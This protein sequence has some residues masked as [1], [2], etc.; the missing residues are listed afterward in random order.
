MENIYEVV[1]FRNSC[2]GKLDTCKTDNIDTA[3]Y[4]FET[5]DSTLLV[6]P[7]HKKTISG[8]DTCPVSITRPNKYVDFYEVGRLG[9]LGGPSFIVPDQAISS[10][11]IGRLCEDAWDFWQIEDEDRVEKI[12]CGIIKQ[13]NA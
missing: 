3:L 4:W 8:H 7:G 13:N 2:T 11:F 9:E 6:Y 5:P 10:K 1:D 12:I